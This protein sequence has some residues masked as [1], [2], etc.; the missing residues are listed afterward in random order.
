MIWFMT[1]EGMPDMT[2]TYQ[3]AMAAGRDA[4]NRQAR[5]NGRAAWSEADFNL[6]ANVTAELLVLAPMKVAG[7][8]S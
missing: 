5:R 4:A 1:P 6:A 3:I 2:I 8:R 7:C